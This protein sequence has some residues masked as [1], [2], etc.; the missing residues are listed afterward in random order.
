M[1]FRNNCTDK[2]QITQQAIGTVHNS[3]PNNPMYKLDASSSYRI[4]SFLKKDEINTLRATSSGIYHKY[5]HCAPYSYN[6]YGS[7]ES[8]RNRRDVQWVVHCHTK[9]V[10]RDCIDKKLAVVAIFFDDDFDQPIEALAGCTHLRH[11]TFGR[12]FD[13]S[14]EALG[15]CTN[16]QRIT[17]G[18]KFNQSIKALSNCTNIRHITFDDA[19]NQPIKALANCTNLRHITFGKDFNHPIKALVKCICLETITFG[20]KSKF[21]QSTSDLINKVHIEYL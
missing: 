14:I 10:L 18:W 20:K 4:S 6:K 16:L 1:K 19:F 8:C 5:R 15:N 3:T 9:E 21:N 13:R 2:Q 12:E 7:D 11:I 17:F